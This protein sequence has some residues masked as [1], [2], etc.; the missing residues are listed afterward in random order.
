MIRPD[1]ISEEVVK[2]ERY[3]PLPTRPSSFKSYNEKP[4]D[5]ACR[6]FE[7]SPSEPRKA[8]FEGITREKRYGKDAAII[9]EGTPTF[10]FVAEFKGHEVGYYIVHWRVNILE[11]FHLPNGLRFSVSVSYDAELE[12][13]SGSFSVAMSSEELEKLVKNNPYDLELEELMVIQPHGE[14]ATVELSLS[15]IESER[16]FQYSGLQVDFVEIRPFNAVEEGKSK[17]KLRQTGSP[18]CSVMLKNDGL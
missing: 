8:T 12:D 13:T 9:P 1:E 5:E 11:G 17:H 18:T 3:S 14:K 7:S 16:R 2:P 6:F 15:N 4:G 10:K